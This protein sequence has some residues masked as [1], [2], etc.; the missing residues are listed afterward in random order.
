MNISIHLSDEQAEHLIMIYDCVKDPDI[1]SIEDYAGELLN[2]L[3]CRI[4]DNV[5]ENI[6]N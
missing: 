3:I 5:R 1:T 6:L 2:D 4:W